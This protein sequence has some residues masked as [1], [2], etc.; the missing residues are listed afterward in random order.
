MP[1]HQK[2]DDEEKEYKKKMQEFK[3]AKDKHG[4]EMPE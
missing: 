3:S 1:L 4:L 2:C